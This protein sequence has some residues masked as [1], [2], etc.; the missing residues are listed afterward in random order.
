[1]NSRTS[2]FVQVLCLALALCVAPAR[3]KTLYWTGSQS[4]NWNHTELNFVDEDGTA[5]AFADLDDVVFDDVHAKV[6]TVVVQLDAAGTTDEGRPSPATIL[7]DTADTF[8]LTNRVS[9]GKIGK[10]LRTITKRGAGKLVL[11]DC[12][13][14]LSTLLTQFSEG[15]YVEAGEVLV[16]KRGLLRSVP[17]AKLR[18]AAGATL[19]IAHVP[20]QDGA[21]DPAFMRDSGLDVEVASGGKF[22]VEEPEE[23]KVIH[24]RRLVLG[25]SAAFDYSNLMGEASSGYISYGLFTVSS[26]VVLGGVGSPHEWLAERARDPNRTQL[27][28]NDS[29]TVDF[30]VADVTASA[31]VD[32]RLD[33]ELRDFLADTTTKDQLP[34]GFKKSGLG[35]MMIENRYSRFSGDI[36]VAAGMLVVG[37]QKGQQ[38]LPD[39]NGRTFLGLMTNENRKIFVRSGATLAMPNCEFLGEIREITNQHVRGEVVVDG[40][41]IDL[42]QGQWALLPNL[43][44]RNGG[45]ISTAVNNR[46]P[47]EGR[48]M[49]HET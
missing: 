11:T 48:V 27:V 20:Q 12:T 6:K 3:A 37:P 10:D 28:L 17:K 46:I 39:A 43:T 18:I 32:F 16:Q 45:T 14:K 42:M 49:F 30:E 41:T 24:F 8:I 15:I 21:G 35:T 47:A 33:F 9:D 22:I 25:D 4:E 7:V 38:Y 40:G 19:K 5:S 1:M 23:K 31:D 2:R 26:N 29:P 36:D 13:S 44:F 34:A